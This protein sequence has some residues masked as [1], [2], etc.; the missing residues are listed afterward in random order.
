MQL[1][2]SFFDQY[3]AFHAV[4]SVRGELYLLLLCDIELLFHDVLNDHMP[5][6]FAENSSDANMVCS[7]THG[8]N[9]HEQ[10]PLRT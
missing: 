9:F 8:S 4:V 3:P 1:R 6:F 5:L 10:I 7:C 2:L